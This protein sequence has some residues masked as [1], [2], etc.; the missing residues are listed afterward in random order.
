MLVLRMTDAQDTAGWEKRETDI[1]TSISPGL[2]RAVLEMA[3]ECS[4]GVCG[5]VP[6]TTLDQGHRNCRGFCFSCGLG[7]GGRFIFSPDPI[8]NI[9]FYT[10]QSLC[11]KEISLRMSMLSFADSYQWF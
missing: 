4:G 7:A 11:K 8:D 1:E 6:V 9:Y 10:L 5:A 3:G 2:G